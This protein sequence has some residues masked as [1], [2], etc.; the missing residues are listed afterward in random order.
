MPRL[1]EPEPVQERDRP[2]AHRDHVTQDPA[3][4]GRRPLEGL[5]RG[6]VVVALDLEGDRLAF[7]EV[8]DAGVLAWSLQDAGAAGR[9]PPEEQRGVLV[10][11]VLRPEQ[12]ED[13][14][15]EVVR[16]ALQQLPD[17]VELS[18]GE[19]ERPVELFRDLRQRSESSREGRR[20]D[21]AIRAVGS[22][23]DGQA[24]VTL[25]A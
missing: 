9:K 5:D 22:K 16:I 18:V 11:A 13:R 1:A 3:D 21:R 17:T 24:R 7:A 25:G 8:D 6:R 12:R 23:V 2:R 19:T 10:C 15:L 4:S 14:E 20:F